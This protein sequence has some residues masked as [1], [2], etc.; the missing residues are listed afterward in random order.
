MLDIKQTPGDDKD[1]IWIV[2]ITLDETVLRFAF[3][4]SGSITLSGNVYTAGIIEDSSLT[5]P[6]K[7]VY[8]DGNQIGTVN[9]IFVS[10]NRWAGHYVN[11]YFPATD[12]PYLV[13]RKIEIGFCWVGAT[14][15]SQITWLETYTVEDQEAEYNKLG[16]FCTEESELE[17]IDLP[18]YSIQKEFDDGISFFESAPDENYGRALPIVYGSL[19]RNESIFDN[20][21]EPIYSPLAE[22]IL[23]DKENYEY[24]VAS[25]KLYTASNPTELEQYIP[26]LGVKAYLV[27]ALTN[28]EHCA[29]LALSGNTVG[30]LGIR[31]LKV[32]DGNP[33]GNIEKS[34]PAYNIV[35]QPGGSTKIGFDFGENAP[36]LGAINEDAIIE[37]SYVAEATVETDT[38]TT[39]MEDGFSGTTFDHMLR[40]G[41]GTFTKPSLQLTISDWKTLLNLVF[42]ITATGSN[43]GTITIKDIIL[44]V[45]G[46]YVKGIYNV[47]VE[48]ITKI[49]TY[50]F[51]IIPVGT[52]D[53]QGWKTEQREVDTVGSNIFA[54]CRGRMFP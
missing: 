40:T 20:R 51:S 7:R 27:S 37:V 46:F 4:P 34:Y 33:I 29:K 43:T 49:P 42:T 19:L 8:L 11:D 48:H 10:L 17:L 38:F 14:L 30:W 24:A 1:L 44:T 28:N 18:F 54:S 31:P 36:E 21:M 35:L 9:N 26:N 13:S 45:K 2:R 16:L 22:C 5:L 15:E 50:W 41:S 52:E 39:H 47:L 23:V 25:H 3:H 32:M 12:K 53:R 6:S